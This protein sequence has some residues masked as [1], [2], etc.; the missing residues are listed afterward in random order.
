LAQAAIESV[1]NASAPTNGF[2]LSDELKNG[3][4]RASFSF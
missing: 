3:A 2:E 1:A 4:F